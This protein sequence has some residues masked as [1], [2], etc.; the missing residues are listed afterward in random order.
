MNCLRSSLSP[1]DYNIMNSSFYATLK[2]AMEKHRTLIMGILNITPDSFSDGG[3]YFNQ[4]DA[5][6]RAMRL[7]E[8][9]ADILDVGGEST[10]PGSDPLPLQEELDRILPVISRISS[11]SPVPISVDTYKADT[12]R[13]AIDAGACLVNDISGLSFDPAMAIVVADREAMVCIMHIQG[14]PKDMQLNPTYED[15]VCDVK[16]W[17]AQQAD[18]GVSQGIPKDHIIIDPGIGFGKTLKHNLEILRRLNEFLELGYPVL[19]GTSRKSFIGKT[20]GGLPPEERMDGTAASVAISIANGANIVRVHDV[21]EMK[22]VAQM[23]DAILF[24]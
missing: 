3:K 23:T 21:L 6:D 11:E 24:H 5:Y 22:R 14:S 12:A 18:Y 10:R 4:T 17:I 1:M 9:G 16:K 8:E 13:H 20:L 19:I 15:V 2:S 7:I